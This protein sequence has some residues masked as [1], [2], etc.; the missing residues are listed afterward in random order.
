MTGAQVAALATPT[1]AT[2]TFCHAVYVGCAG[3]L[4][5][6][7]QYVEAP[8]V[9]GVT[10][11]VVLH[12]EIEVIVIG[13]G[14]AASMPISSHSG[15]AT[16]VAAEMSKQRADSANGRRLHETKDIVAGDRVVELEVSGGVF[17]LGLAVL[18]Q[19]H[20]TERGALGQGAMG[21]HSSA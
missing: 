6:E 9:Y 1:L 12:E 18:V 2:V 10:V 20:E 8:E 21:L 17:D 15:H 3:Q 7:T 4:Q 16:A 11:G 14:G 19:C 13:I 5:D